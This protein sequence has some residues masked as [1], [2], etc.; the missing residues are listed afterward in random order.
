MRAATA[1]STLVV[2]LAL[3]AATAARADVS[4]DAR[5]RPP[6]PHT[7][8]GPACDRALADAQATLDWR[9]DDV[10]FQTRERHVVGDYQW[11][12]MCGV[13]GNYSLEL[14]PDLRPA[15]P[16]RWSERV[17]R[18]NGRAHRR[19]VLRARGVRATFILDADDPSDLGDWFVEAF[20]PAVEACLATASAPR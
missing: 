20:R 9:A 2:A 5:R 18:A 15:Q 1:A 17:D 14:A 19:G 4:L 3:V 11:S 16:W 10:H 8:L 7:P 13:W 6:T 12:D